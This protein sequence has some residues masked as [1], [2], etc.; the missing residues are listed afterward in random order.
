MSDNHN[1]CVIMAGGYGSRF[2]PLSRASKPKQFISFEESGDTFLRMTWERMKKVVP[3]ENIIVVSLTRYKDTV[4]E[5]LPELSERNL[6]LE[7]YNRNTGPCLAFV[8]YCLLK[9][10]PLAVFVATPADHLIKDTDSFVR[11]LH[12]AL[13]YAARC[14]ELVSIGVPPTRPDANF[15]YIQMAGVSMDGKPVKVKTFTEKPDVEL[16]SVFI[17]T[18]EFLW[19]TGIFVWRASAIRDELEMHAP[20]ITRLWKGWKDAL[21]SPAQEDFLQKV[22]ADMPRISIDYAVME[23]TEHARVYPASFDWAD[24]GNWESLH[25]YLAT[26]DKWGNTVKIS[27]KSLVENCSGNIVYSDSPRKLIA[28]RG[29]E[30]YVVI[31]TGDVLMI[32]PREEDKLKDFISEIAMPEYEEYR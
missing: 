27:G 9:R 15:G 1:Y 20:E 24:I 13:A 29:L 32:C 7:P 11:T 2:W 5:V 25:D 26:K 6:L 12:N 18:G 23:K 14:D 28:V 22:Y 21:D 30:D 19:N 3:E 8:T 17:A 16:A 10:D 31:D 4:M